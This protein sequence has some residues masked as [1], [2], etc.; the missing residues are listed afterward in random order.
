MK[1]ELKDYNGRKYIEYSDEEKKLLFNNAEYF[2]ID[3]KSE[4]FVEIMSHT[5]GFVANMTTRYFKKNN[6]DVSYMLFCCIPQE[7]NDFLFSFVYLDDKY[8]I[9]ASELDDNYFDYSYFKNKFTDCIIKE[10][11]TFDL[12][13]IESLKEVTDRI[14]SNPSVDFNLKVQGKQVHFED[15]LIYRN[16][17]IFENDVKN[18]LEKLGAKYCKFRFDSNC[19]NFITLRGV[20]IGEDDCLIKSFQVR[21]GYKTKSEYVD[22]MKKK[23]EGYTEEDVSDN[24]LEFD[25]SLNI[26]RKIADNLEFYSE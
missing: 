20:V 3:V 22:L 26:A 5:G 23:H 12:E 19:L 13:L 7:Y 10:G 15:V 2:I 1:F 21:S 17:D 4:V 9:L 18:N 24:V 16:F 14:C 25:L 8:N 11:Y 6:I